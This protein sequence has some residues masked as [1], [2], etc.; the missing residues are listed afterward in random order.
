MDRVCRS[1]AGVRSVTADNPGPM[2][3]DGTRTYVVGEETAL[4]LD[5]GPDGPGSEERWR[6]AAE[7]ADIRLVL[8]THSHSDHAAGAEAAADLFGARVAATG[9]TLRRLSARGRPLHDG[10]EIPVDGGRWR[11]RAVETPGHSGD[12]VCFFRPSDRLL[13]TG[14]LVL[15]EGSS[16]VAYPDGRVGEYLSSLSRLVDME[17]R[18]ILPGHGPDVTDA[19]GRL[20]EYLDHRR[21]RERQVLEAVRAGATSVEEIRGR[22]YP[23]LPEGLAWAASANVAAHLQHLRERGEEVPAPPP[24]EGAGGR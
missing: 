6:S 14:D 8:L 9:E 18:V 15:G 23:G 24:E 10:E 21:E 5:P 3:L 11:L 22:V 13:F 2:T 12:H 16:L 7:G 20:R 17:P 1:A 19:V 4:L